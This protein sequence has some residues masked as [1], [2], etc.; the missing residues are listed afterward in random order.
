M[1]LLLPVMNGRQLKV[2]SSAS[3]GSNVCR[4]RLSADGERQRRFPPEPRAQ[5]CW[6]PE[7]PLMFVTGTP[8]TSEVVE[9]V[10]PVRVT[11]E[12]ALNP[13]IIT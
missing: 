9:V 5:N 12:K 7:A 11:P 4:R 13:R 2:G 3:P 6:E 8:L 1:F 10:R